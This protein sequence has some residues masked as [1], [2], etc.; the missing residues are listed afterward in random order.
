MRWIIYAY[1]SHLTP[2]RALRNRLYEYH[3]FY[4]WG[5]LTYPRSPLN[6]WQGRRSRLG[7]LK[8]VPLPLHCPVSKSRYVLLT[9]TVWF[10]QGHRRASIQS[11]DS[12]GLATSEGLAVTDFCCGKLHNSILFFLLPTLATLSKEQCLV[13][14]RRCKGIDWKENFTVFQS[15]P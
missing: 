10:T 9:T 4:S 11:T 12:P 1:S 8:P 13:F 14:T 7:L 6:K 5:Q 3:P 2:R 15:C